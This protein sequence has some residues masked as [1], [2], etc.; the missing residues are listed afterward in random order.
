M[1]KII[2]AALAALTLS[3]AALAQ[4]V[5]LPSTRRRASCW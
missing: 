2:A 4:T 1:K 3:G 5:E